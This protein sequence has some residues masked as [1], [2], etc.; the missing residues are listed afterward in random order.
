MPKTSPSTQSQLFN[1][2]ESLEAL[3]NDK[4]QDPKTKETKP[5]ST[6]Q[7]SKPPLERP[8]LPRQPAKLAQPA[9]P[10]PAQPKQPVQA[11]PKPASLG[12]PKKPQA[13]FEARFMVAYDPIAF[14]HLF[15]F[16]ETLVEGL[17]S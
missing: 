4:A 16:Q 11:V 17:Q 3:L 2:L 12:L 7:T 10:K 14:R 9:Q 1:A 15:G 6:Q 8:P 5:Q 13:Q